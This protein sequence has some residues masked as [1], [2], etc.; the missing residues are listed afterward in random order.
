VVVTTW[1]RRWRQNPLL[2]AHHFITVSLG[3][4]VVTAVASVMYAVAFQPIPLRDVPQIVQVWQE[5]ESGGVG[6]LSGTELLEMQQ[7]SEEIFADLGGFTLQSWE[8]G[9]QGEV[10]EVLVARL[11]RAA[12]RVL[13][14]HPIV[15]RPVGAE[16]TTRSLGPVWISSRLWQGRYGARPSVVDDTVVLTAGSSKVRAEIAGVL[17]SDVPFSHPE[18]NRAIDV[19]AVLPDDLKRRAERSRVFFALGRLNPDRTFAEAKA[20]LAAIAD[21]RSDA[22]DRRRRPVLQ[23]IE[24]VAQGPARRTFGVW[25]VALALVLL[26]AFVNLSGLTLIEASRRRLELSMR[27]SLGASPSRLWREIA[28]E[29]SALSI[30]ALGLGLPMA[31]IALQLLSR[32]LPF[33]DLGP[34]LTRV[35]SMN[36]FVMLGFCVCSLA[37]SL[38]WSALIV[39][40]AGRLAC[41][42]PV[43]LTR[44]ASA[45]GFDD[46]DRRSSMWRL[47]ALSVQTCFGIA[48]MVVAV[49]MTRSYMGATQ[50]NLGPA[51][52]R[53]V[54]IS[55]K[56]QDTKAMTSA[57]AA[58]FNSRILS[59][60]RAVPQV[61]EVAF[62][63]IFPPLGL[64]MSFWKSDDLAEAPRETTTPLRVSN[65]YFETL[66]IPILFGR[67][68]SENDRQTS[69]SVAIVDVE[70]A[71]RNWGSP[72]AAVGEQI[73]IGS[74][75]RPYEVIGV[76]GSFNGYWS[77]IPLPTLFLSQNQQPSAGGDV[78]IRAETSA[79]VT[80]ERSRQ[81]LNGMTVRPM[82]SSPATLQ[83][84]WQATT[85]RPRVRMI[86]VLLL[87]VLGLA[88][89]AQGIYTLVASTIAA[90]RQELAIRTALGAPAGALEWLI[91]GQVFVAVALGSLAGVAAILVAQRFA[92][93]SISGALS[94]PA[95]IIGIAAAILMCTGLI[96]AYIPARA[97]VRATSLA[98]LLRF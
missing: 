8:V 78:I 80:A 61:D 34:P 63:D 2:A 97:A 69:Q 95:T 75:A 27:T 1:L 74:S 57:Q 46:S 81:L 91:L 26:L 20:V 62:A 79:T 33:M 72:E 87:A 13:N 47:G 29:Q 17:P 30:L 25:S 96:A 12:F 59:L 65:D 52:D 21:R 16:P 56:P 41:D 66:G 89:G 67:V 39:R 28:A 88:L 44:H 84:S 49:S 85:T 23:G 50:V 31:W 3:M 4:A 6:A 83:A 15:G 76:V 77:Q 19:W 38:V 7:G 24:D 55:V 22:A 42:S 70:M 60:L 48:L 11:E 93:Y 92:P 9:D 71:R 58:D 53:T 10:E 18:I 36:Y 86:G 5:S 90:R 14:I 37:A 45:S 54:V 94:N 35:P 64:P 98:A 73:R 40:R 43:F 32:L 68:F 51:P 82:V